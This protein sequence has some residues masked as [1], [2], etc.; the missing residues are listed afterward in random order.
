MI[1]SRLTVFVSCLFVLSFLL[2]PSTARTAKTQ[3]GTTTGN[4]LVYSTNGKLSLFVRDGITG[5]GVK[6]EI[7]LSSSE[8]SYLLST[9]EGGILGFV[10]ESGRCDL[11]IN[12][13]GYKQMKTF[14]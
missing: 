11:T 14:F 9:N 6:S 8:G 3:G 7:V 5:Y 2:A 13:P 10:A 12:T 1:Q 4:A